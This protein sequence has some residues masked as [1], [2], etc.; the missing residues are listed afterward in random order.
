M[1]VQSDSAFLEGDANHVRPREPSYTVCECVRE[2]SYRAMSLLSC[3]TKSI[4]AITLQCL[5]SDHEP[6][7][8]FP[9]RDQI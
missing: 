2:Q 8:S 1:H 3:Y 6:A 7:L 5:L 9:L 4:L